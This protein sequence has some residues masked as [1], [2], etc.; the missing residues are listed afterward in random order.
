M[1]D[2]DASAVSWG[3]IIANCLSFFGSVNFGFALSWTAASLQNIANDESMP[4]FSQR[5]QNW[6]SVSSSLQNV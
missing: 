2:V 4:N 3:L 1:K 5:E 6:V